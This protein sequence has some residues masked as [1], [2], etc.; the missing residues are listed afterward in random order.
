ML[1]IICDLSSNYENQKLTACGVINKEL[2]LWKGIDSNGALNTFFPFENIT[3]SFIDLLT[4]CPRERIKEFASGT[5]II[6][7]IT[8]SECT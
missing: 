4:N 5:S 1:Y 8:V 7:G 6:F 2:V 3:I